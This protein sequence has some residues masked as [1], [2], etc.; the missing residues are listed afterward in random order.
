MKRIS[1]T[2]SQLWLLKEIADSQKTE[3]TFT[4]NTGSEM[5][6]NAQNAV[7]DAS[8]SGLNTK[9]TILNGRSS[10]NN[11]SDNDEVAIAPDSS[12]ST[13]QDAVKSA[14]DKAVSNGIDKNKIVIKGSTEDILNGVSEGKTFSK[15]QILEA[16]IARMEKNCCSFSKEKFMNELQ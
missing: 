8:K 3:I 4:G 12:K 10:T 9:N 6:Y 13:V 15:N 2:E 14:Y 11:A 1:I 7:N 16:K 5:G